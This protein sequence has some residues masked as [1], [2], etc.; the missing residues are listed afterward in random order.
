MSAP[1][2]RVTARLKS[3]VQELHI[4]YETAH[5]LYEPSGGVRMVG[6][7]SWTS[8]V[9]EDDDQIAWVKVHRVPLNNGEDVAGN[10]DEG[11]PVPHT[12][13]YDVLDTGVG[14]H[15][16]PSV[17]SR[18]NPYDLETTQ[19][20]DCTFLIVETGWIDPAWHGLQVSALVLCTILRELRRDSDVIAASFQLPMMDETGKPLKENNAVRAEWRAAYAYAGFRRFRGK[21]MLLGDT[22]LPETVLPALEL[23]FGFP[24]AFVGGP[25]GPR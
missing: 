6:E 10:L 4:R 13:A 16:L 1:R 3:R 21:T 11:M 2:R 24:S 7:R 20:T 25:H 23:K 14:D 8:T 22:R 5:R 18:L 17:L 9:Y 15:L 12:P 19:T